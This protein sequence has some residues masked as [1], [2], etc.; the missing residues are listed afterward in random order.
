[1]SW[2][3]ALFYAA[4]LGQIGLISHYFPRRIVRRMR[5][6]L[7]THQPDDYPKLTRSLRSTTASA[8]GSSSRQ[9]E[10][11]LCWDSCCCC[12]SCSG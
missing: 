2:S 10:R 6:V 9:T 11:L 7:D 5:H 12:P 1:M 3:D 8:S 4:F